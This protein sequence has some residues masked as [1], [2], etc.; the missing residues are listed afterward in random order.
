MAKDSGSCN[1]ARVLESQ[2][3]N[4]IC[5]LQYNALNEP[6]W[7]HQL[8]PRSTLSYVMLA[9]LI[10]SVLMV[11]SA[12][13]SGQSVRLAALP[14]TDSYKYVTGRY[15]LYLQSTRS[16]CTYTA[17]P[18]T[19]TRQANLRSMSVL[20]TRGKEGGSACNGVFKFEQLQVNCSNQKIYYDE[21][22]AFAQSPQWFFSP[23]IAVKVC[24]L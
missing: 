4:W 16:G 8:M 23:E 3:Y 1:T 22:L 19:L 11:S 18:Q 21:Q 9:G 14:D 24:S 5:F 15:T 10:P 12:M 17:N 6:N 2:S 7:L 20:L 13:A